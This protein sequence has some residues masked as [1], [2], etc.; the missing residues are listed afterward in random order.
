[1]Y[2]LLII[3]PTMPAN[4]IT[5]NEIYLQ[6][7][8]PHDGSESRVQQLSDVLGYFVVGLFGLGQIV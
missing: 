5:N 3:I 8:K 6:R 1:M 2:Q 7:C 4:T